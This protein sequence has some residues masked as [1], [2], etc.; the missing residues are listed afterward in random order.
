MLRMRATCLVVLAAVAAVGCE[1]VR[2]ASETQLRYRAVFDLGCPSEQLQLHRLGGRARAVGGCGRRLVYVERCEPAVGADDACS[3]ML[4]APVMTQ[5][6]WPQELEA[7]RARAEQLAAARPAW[8]GAAP[9]DAA[10][11]AAPADA[12]AAAPSATPRGRTCPAGLFGDE[13]MS[14]PPPSDRIRKAPTGLFDDRSPGR[15]PVPAG[16]P[17]FGF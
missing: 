13:R 15:A 12:T 1:P 17:D 3:W 7:R 4:D 16:E 2:R 9:P 10:P 14:A 11:E 5:S 6:E 8:W